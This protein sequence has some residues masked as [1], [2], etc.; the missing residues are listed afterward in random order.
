MMYKYSFYYSVQTEIQNARV[1]SRQVML[2]CLTRLFTK[3]HFVTRGY[4]FLFKVSHK[5]RCES[6]LL[7]GIRG[8]GDFRVCLLVILTRGLRRR[9]FPVARNCGLSINRFTGLHAAVSL[10]PHC[11]THKS[12]FM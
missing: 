11:G 5:K 2:D 7:M 8:G 1:P 12:T 9:L 10:Q 4:L 6:T 3:A